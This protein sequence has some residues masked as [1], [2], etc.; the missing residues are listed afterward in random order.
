[1]TL[2]RQGKLT[3]RRVF[4]RFVRLVLT[5]LAVVLAGFYGAANGAKRPGSG[6]AFQQLPVFVN[7]APIDVRD[8]WIVTVPASRSSSLH[9]NAES[10]PRRA[11]VSSASAH[12]ANQ[13]EPRF[14]SRNAAA[15]SGV[16]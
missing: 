9:C 13:R 1:M 6:W 12:S 5:L 8:A 4:P 2:A 16:Q 3:F 11:P 10:S 14:A 7:L 15:C